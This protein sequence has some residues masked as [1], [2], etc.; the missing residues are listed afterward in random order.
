MLTTYSPQ[1]KCTRTI[2]FTSALLCF[3]SALFAAEDTDAAAL[4]KEIE[5]LRSTYQN[6][7]QQL[8]QRVQ[9]LETTGA[10][11]S[12]AGAVAGDSMASSDSS[13][14][15]A[16]L[17]QIKEEL[18][19]DDFTQGFTFNGY[20]RS[21]F[22]VDKNGDAMRA[23]RAPNAGSKFRLGNETETYVETAFGY[24]F[25]QLGLAEG[26]EFSIGFRPSYVV[27]DN[28]SSTASTFSVREAYAKAK[29]V[30]EA[31]GDASFWAGQRFYQRYD[32]HM[33]DFYYLDMS[34]YGGGVEDVQ[35]GDFSKFDIAW[36]GGSIDALEGGA[37]IV[38]QRVVN[39]KNS[40]DIRFRDISV[41]G[42]KGMVWV[43]LAHVN[44][45]NKPNGRNVQTRGGAGLALGF[46]HEAQG[47]FGGTNRA[48][49]LG[50]VGAAA[51]FQSTEPDF[52]DFPF[53][54][55]NGEYDDTL[56]VDYKDIWHVRFVNDLVVQPSDDWTMQM[57]FVYD[58]FD[59]GLVGI[60]SKVQWISFGARP[61]YSITDHFSLAFE[62]GVD[63][64]DADF[65]NSGQVYKFTFAPQITPG[66]GHFARPALRVF[67]TYAFWSDDFKGQVL[68]DN[69][70]DGLNIGVQAE[71]WW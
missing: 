57:V 31:Q 29:G 69:S 63:H 18:K 58:H 47:V 4:R 27:P 10:A 42:G 33:S 26:K 71:A 25:P 32:V 15:P 44:D 50:G 38:D 22:G 36:I 64:T 56:F 8:E 65:Q 49:L 1:V 11:P 28:K 21:G 54:K 37:E 5:Q 3:G 2:L 16:Q 9:E 62:A 55:T 45:A 51:N 53:D 59:A 19:K 61:V 24:T 43:D 30:W 66:R 23:Y 20:F 46:M 7:I 39:T 35:L 14:S 67:A 52:G 60:D 40:L 12:A 70:T 41:P 34:G 13:L 48:T 6:Q 68:P 17:E